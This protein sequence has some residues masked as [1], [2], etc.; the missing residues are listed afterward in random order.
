MKLKYN[1]VKNF[2]LD[3]FY[4]NRCPCCNNL[5]KWNELLCENCMNE[6]SD[7]HDYGFCFRCGRTPCICEKQEIFYERAFVYKPYENSVRNGILEMKRG[8]NINFG[9]FAGTQ[10]AE[11]LKGTDADFIVPV[12]MSARKKHIRR[13]NQA[14]VIARQISE[15][16]DIPVRNDILY[17]KY[18]KTE[19]HSRNKQDRIAVRNLIGINDVAD[20]KNSKIILCDDIITTANTVNFCSQLLKSKGAFYVVTALSAGAVFKDED[21]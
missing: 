17:M 7:M 3:I 18:S 8:R 19:Q 12:P 14:E 11:M 21:D 15:I 1:D 13:Y 2:I 16:L 4:P 6:I 10:L 20:I 9:K 5:I